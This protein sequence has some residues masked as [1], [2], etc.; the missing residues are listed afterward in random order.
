MLSIKPRI[1]YIPI[2]SL[3]SD[4]ASLLLPHLP[5]IKKTNVSHQKCMILYG[6]LIFHTCYT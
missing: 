2:D 3:F 5:Q 4:V 1:F 6:L